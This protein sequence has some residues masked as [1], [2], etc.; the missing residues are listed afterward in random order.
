M[1]PL[2]RG[3]KSNKDDRPA[4]LMGSAPFPQ[5]IASPGSALRGQS[6]KLIETAATLHLVEAPFSNMRD[7]LCL[8]VEILLFCCAKH[9]WKYQVSGNRDFILDWS[10]NVTE[11]GLWLK[12]CFGGC[13]HFPITEGS[14]KK[15]KGSCLS[16]SCI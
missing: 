1:I 12:K 8:H 2:S 15:K 5:L 6:Q 4:L 11:A 10:E 3:Q 14:F 7:W 13:Q 16:S 9:K